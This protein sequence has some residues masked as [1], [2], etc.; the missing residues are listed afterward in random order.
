MRRSCL[1]Q[2]GA[3]RVLP[4]VEQAEAPGSFSAPHESQMI[5][6][7]GGR[8]VDRAVDLRPCRWDRALAFG[9]L[10]KFDLCRRPNKRSRLAE[11]RM[12]TMEM[13]MTNAS[14]TIPFDDQCFFCRNPDTDLR[15]RNLPDGQQVCYPHADR[16]EDREG[17]PPSGRAIIYTDR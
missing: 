8:F 5:G 2:G 3:K 1:T 15:W 12:D 14:D 13:I 4:Q 9:L 17:L 11:E 16:I 10:I 7:G 6:G